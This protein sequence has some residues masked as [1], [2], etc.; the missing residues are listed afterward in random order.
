[1]TLPHARFEQWFKLSDAWRVALMLK[2]GA[3]AETLAAELQ[4]QYPGL[5]VFSQRHLR[6][7]A[8]R[9]FRQTFA[10]TYALEAV[11]VVVAIAGLGLAL[12]SLMLDRKTDLM[13]LRSLGFSAQQIARSCAWEG[14]GIAVA[15][16]A[17]GMTSGLWL[18][19]LLIYRVNKQSF[20]WTLSFD[21]P[22]AQMLAL[23]FMILSTAAIISAFVGQW[24][25]RL[26]A[27][28]HE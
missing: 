20:G 16:V 5:S 9:I 8:I 14:M 17:V 6:G 4:K 11:G 3:D 1:M 19:W 2:P 15:G 24:S 23:G 22:A 25:A 10:V 12:A 28:Q 18:G 13:T 26:K 21:F 27:E 7:E